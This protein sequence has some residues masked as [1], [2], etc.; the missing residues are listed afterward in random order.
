ME[1]LLKIV[2][3]MPLQELW[4]PDGYTSKDRKS[5]LS[6]EDIKR[7]LQLGPVQFVVIDV[8]LAPKWIPV[9]ERFDFW[10][11]EVLC[12]LAAPDSKP[13]L[14]DFPGS[15]FYWASEWKSP[16]GSPPVVVLEMCH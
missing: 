7:M 15:Y 11:T 3:L 14:N 9:S 13:S 5:Y 1:T 8:G 2:T 10:K 6:E 12:H 16:E 4:W